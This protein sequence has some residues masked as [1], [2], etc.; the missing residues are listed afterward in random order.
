[1]P[2]RQEEFGA[3]IKGGTNIRNY[4]E[5]NPS[6]FRYSTTIYGNFSFEGEPLLECNA[7]KESAPGRYVVKVSAGT[8]DDEAVE[9]QD[10]VLIVR[11]PTGVD[12]VCA[13]EEQRYKVYTLD[14]KFI[15]ECSRLDNFR[16]GIYIVNGK[17]VL[18]KNNYNAK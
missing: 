16:R 18:L 4:G 17:K 1:M 7:T 11:A 8:I 5:E 15:Q 2:A 9:Y 3:L 6:K 14:G 12:A 13:D 10:G